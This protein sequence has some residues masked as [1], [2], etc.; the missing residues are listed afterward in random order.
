M[1]A[2]E[3]AVIGNF[4]WV[5][6][7][8]QNP[9]KGKGFYGELFGWKSEDTKLPV[10]DYTLMKIGNATVAGLLELPPNARKNGAPPHW[11]SYVAVEDAAAATAKALKLGAK[12]LMLATDVGPGKMAV[13]A[14]PT[15]AVFALW[16]SVES[17]GT[18]DVWREPNSMSWLELTT[19]DPAAATKFYV[20]MFGWRSEAAPMGDFVYTLLYN[21]KEQIAGLMPQPKPM[22]VAK[23]PSL[24]TVYFE[25]LDCDATA[26]KA[27]KLGGDIV[28]P[29]T[30]IPNVGRF[31]ILKDLDGAAFAIIKNT[32]K[33]Q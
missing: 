22:V 19:T 31:A 20:E 9:Q 24:W 15:G 17:A 2:I 18:F 29:P 8:L 7:N 27:K 10:G 32:P 28:M 23:A 11:L 33:S 14:D 21:G 6:A 12:V 30:D 16:Q 26:S 5:E 25:V 1:P 13:I 3:K 4:C